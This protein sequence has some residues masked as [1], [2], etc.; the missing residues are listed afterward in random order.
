MIYK[1]YACLGLKTWIAG[2][3]TT[4]SASEADKAVK[5]LHY[6][7]ATRVYKGIFDAI[8]QMQTENLTNSY[9]SIDKVLRKNLVRLRKIID[10]SNFRNILQ[11]SEFTKLEEQIVDSNSTQSWM[12]VMLLEDI[13][14]LLLFFSAARI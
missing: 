14:L 9:D 7:T 8:L 10:I 2:A 6:N 5:S 13:S 11:L 4:Q 3:G 12:I 1:R